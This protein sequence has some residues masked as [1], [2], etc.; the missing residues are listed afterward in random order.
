M[1][2]PT[3]PL[4]C[5]A[6]FNHPVSLK[7]FL[8]YQCAAASPDLLKETIQ[9]ALIHLLLLPFTPSSPQIYRDVPISNGARLN[10]HSTGKQKLVQQKRAENVQV[11]AIYN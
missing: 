2:Q 11:S 7:Q 6:I 8:L 5:S 4:V 10:R 3:L 1:N 9:A